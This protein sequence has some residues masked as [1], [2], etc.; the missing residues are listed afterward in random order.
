MK[1]NKSVL[2]SILIISVLGLVVFLINWNRKFE[3]PRQNTPIIEFTI[4]KDTT[5][6]A[7]I[8]DLAYYHFIKDEKAFK[9]A[10]KRSKDMSTGR[11]GSLIIGR[12]TI[13]R[14][15]KYMISQSMTVW[16]IADVL[17]NQGEYS[18]CEHGCPNSNFSPELLPGGD[19]APTIQQKYE[20]VKTY[21]DCVK[22]IGNDGG[23]LSSEQYA[24]K[25]GVRKCV[26]PDS[27]EF[28]K[29]KDGWTD[30]IGG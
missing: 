29:G 11:D 3:A 10:L 21:E 17:L 19:L 2:L 12:N 25:T 22:T 8:S 28:T 24:E 20:W 7:V 6:E 5:L 23:Q 13:N 1:T 14:E 26:S 9:F 16:E 15:A 4:R 30:A 18:S 27:R